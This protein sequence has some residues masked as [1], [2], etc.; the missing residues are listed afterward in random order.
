V[1]GCSLST[2]FFIDFCDL[3]YRCG[4]NSLWNGAAQACNIHSH[5]NRHCPWCSI[6]SAGAVAVWFSVISVQCFVAL[7]WAGL[8]LILR[9]VLTLA[10]FPITAGILALGM[11]VVLNYWK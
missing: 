11:G 7:G 5:G 8:P 2:V 9:V 3:V 1:A 10:A 6:G 4:C